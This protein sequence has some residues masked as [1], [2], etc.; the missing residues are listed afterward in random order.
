MSV[1]ATRGGWG[2]NLYEEMYCFFFSPNLTWRDVQHLIVWTSE[3]APLSDNPGWQIN[4][5]VKLFLDY[6]LFIVVG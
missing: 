4:G 6:F 1:G 2:Q 3:Y 5:Y